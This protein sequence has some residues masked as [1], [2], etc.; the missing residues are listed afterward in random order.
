M[1]AGSPAFRATHPELLVVDIRSM[2]DIVA[3]QLAPRRFVMWT[4]GL[5]GLMAILIAAVGLY[6]ILAHA[7]AQRAHE[8]GIRMALGADRRDLRALVLREGVVTAI[9]GVAVGVVGSLAAM[10]LLESLLL[11]RTTSDPWLWIL[12][13]LFVVT[14]ALV[15]SLVPARRAA[16]TD[17]IVALRGV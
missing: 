15:S 9:A 10:R 4:L 7:V 12:V 16:R 13:P 17:P 2:D 8:L 6:G 1:L 5:F 3:T 14:V 11:P